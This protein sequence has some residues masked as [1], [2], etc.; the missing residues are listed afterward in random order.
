MN[1][2]RTIHID[3]ESTITVLNKEELLL[4]HTPHSLQFQ[5][6]TEYLLLTFSS[7]A[8]VPP[9]TALEIQFY[10]VLALFHDIGKRAI[11]LAILNKPRSLTAEEFEV[12]KTHTTQ[13]C[14]ILEEHPELRQCGVL[15]LLCD[16]CRHHY[17]RWDGGGYPDG[18]TGICIAPWVQV[19]GLADAFDA[20]IHPRAYKGAYSADQARR[21]I[22]SG[23]C[24]A[25]DPQMLAA[26][27]S[28]ISG[29]ARAVYGESI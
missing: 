21:M 24:G 29:I 19:V 8:V 3:M 17:E 28:E 12:V 22:A 2:V 9:L 11:P 20:L 18:L 16:V 1:E 6:L 10:S 25:F 13:G 4:E 26:F 7:A 15:P 27:N 5:T 14:R 23:A